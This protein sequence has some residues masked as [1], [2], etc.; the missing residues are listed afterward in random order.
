MPDKIVTPIPRLDIISITANDQFVTFGI[1]GDDASVRLAVRDLV[2]GLHILGAIEARCQF[3]SDELKA[4]QEDA[5]MLWHEKA[6]INISIATK[7]YARLV[8]VYRYFSQVGATV[9]NWDFPSTSGFMHP[10]AWTDDQDGTQHRGAAVLP[11]YLRAI[12]ELAAKDNSPI[13]IPEYRRPECSLLWSQEEWHAERAKLETGTG[14]PGFFAS[15]SSSSTSVLS[16]KANCD[17]IRHKID[18]MVSKNPAMLFGSARDSTTSYLEWVVMACEGGRNPF[19]PLQV[20]SDYHLIHP[21]DRSEFLT[22]IR[23][24][25]ESWLRLQA[26]KVPAPAPAFGCEFL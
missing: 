22:L 25:H 8:L 13:N 24:Y 17:R 9:P 21:E 14:G 20:S 10:Y 3:I 5:S 11:F 16:D 19:D 6:Q 4:A 2:S 1:S 26:E 23:E 7:E 18:L 12:K 15:S